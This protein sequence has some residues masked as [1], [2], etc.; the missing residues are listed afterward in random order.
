[1]AFRRLLAS[2]ILSLVCVLAWP[3]SSQEI[4]QT[5]IAPAIDPTDDPWLAEQGPAA[6][7]PVEVSREQVIAAWFEAPEA[8]YAR[9]AALREVR[10]ELGVG[11]L[12]APARVILSAATLEDPEIYTGFARDLAPGVPA[13][14]LEHARALAATGDVGGAMRATLAGFNVLVRSLRAQLWAV[15]NLS[16]LLMIVVLAASF[17][18]IGL[19]ALQVFP[20]L[21]HDLGDLLGG[22]RM[23]AFAR[24][25]ALAALL[26]I[27]LVLGEGVLGL[28]LGLF[29]VAFAY[30]KTRQRNVLSMA[31]VLL[32]LGLHPLA[33]F[34]SVATTLVDQDPI[35]A[36]VMAVIAGSET[37][38]DVERLETV[39][40]TELIAAHALVYRD[41]RYGLEEASRV[42]LEK[43]AEQYPGDG[44]VLAARGNIEMRRGDSDA[45][46]EFYER[47]AAQLNSAS[48]LFDLSQAYANKFRMEEYETTLVRAQQ[49]DA[50][51]VA[52]L[53][54]LG[55]PMLVADLPFPTGLL[56][57]RFLTL[58]MS[59]DSQVDLAA[60]LAPGRLGKDWSMT[61]GGFVL[62]ALFCLL[63]AHRFDHSSQCGRCGHRICTRCEETVWS[64]ELCEDCHH[65]FTNPAATDP[66]L[67]MARLQALSKREVWIGGV[68][69]SASLLIPGVAGLVARRPDFAMFG[70]LLFGWIVAWVIWP[71][72][73]FEDPL[74][75]GV[76]AVICFAVLGSLATIGYVGI[77]WASL[78]ARRKL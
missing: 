30:G 31:A 43:M 42:R 65:L 53:S 2:S 11:D 49:I 13:I 61:A 54:S 57:A 16:V 18:F 78:A 67:R 24:S 41:R 25:A 28:A 19:S 45:A 23:P 29:L 48:L 76:A 10:L 40:D 39:V 50:D 38:A 56:Q 21:S 5:A 17:G 44:F 51:V 34:V 72:G 20:H 47:A 26:L 77:V 69:T 6:A 4:A 15:E 1:M 75:M 27:P 64:E 71:A 8:A 35:A 62:A 66:S 55:D 46:I 3:V 22:R 32:V 12:L 68:L 63:F 36:S 33:Q 74:G 60:V 14:Q 73:L 52:D 7:V 37:Q 59:Q 9:T 58:A 70:L